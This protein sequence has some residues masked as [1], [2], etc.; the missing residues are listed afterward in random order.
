MLAKLALH[1]N[2]T[3][4]IKVPVTLLK[5][6]ARLPLLDINVKRKISCFFSVGQSFF[7]QDLQRLA[8]GVGARAHNGP[9]I[10]DLAELE[11]GTLWASDC[12][13][14]TSPSPRD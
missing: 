11:M 5:D 10:V 12:L 2:R 4:T 3:V 13:L 8:H 14:Y 7:G 1:R 6:P 9:D